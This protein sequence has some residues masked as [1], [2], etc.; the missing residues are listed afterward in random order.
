MKRPLFSPLSKILDQH[1]GERVILSRISRQGRPK[2]M[3]KAVNPFGLRTDVSN[4]LGNEPGGFDRAG[5]STTYP[6]ISPRQTDSP[7]NSQ[8][9]NRMHLWMHTGVKP[10]YGTREAK[11]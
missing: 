5:V 6:R 2:A 11:E 10:L 7:P 4:R 9:I 8:S 1:G 3:A